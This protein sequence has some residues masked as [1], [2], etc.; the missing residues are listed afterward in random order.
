LAQEV[1]LELR[2][3]RELSIKQIAL[4]EVTKLG[5]RWLAA[6]GSGS[7]EDDWQDLVLAADLNRVDLMALG[8]IIWPW[9]HGG[10]LESSRPMR[11]SGLFD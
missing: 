3:L 10:L 11:E 1:H 2:Y 9:K 4:V 5:F 6:L 8:R 7:M